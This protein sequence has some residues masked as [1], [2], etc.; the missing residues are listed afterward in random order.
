MAQAQAQPEDEIQ[1]KEANSSSSSASV[2]FRFNVQAPEFVPKSHTTQVPF[3]GYY[4]PCFHYTATSDW[5]FVGDQE[6]LYLLSNPN[7]SLP[8][9]SKNVLTDDLRQKI[10]KQVCLHFF[11]L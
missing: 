11:D 9:S 4:Y 6:P 5:I 1:E 10:V 2:P 3:S 8:N 7:I